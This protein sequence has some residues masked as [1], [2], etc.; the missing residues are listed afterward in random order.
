M[1]F[2]TVVDYHDFVCKEVA[3]S[4]LN[5]QLHNI[6][7]EPSNKRASVGK[8][9]ARAIVFNDGATLQFQEEIELDSGAIRR[10]KYSY[11]YSRPDYFFRYDKDSASVRPYV[12]AECHL[13]ANAEEPRYVTHE[14]SFEEV[15]RFIWQVFT[16]SHFNKRYARFLMSFHSETVYRAA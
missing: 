3:R 5:S 14:T 6:K 4:G 13:H 10:I 1:R 12:H 2:R 11:H 7:M 9:Q 16:A 8:V 15:F